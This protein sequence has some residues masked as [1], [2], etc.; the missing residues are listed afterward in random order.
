MKSGY[1]NFLEFSG[2][3][4]ACNGTALASFIVLRDSTVNISSEKKM[5]YLDLSLSLSLSLDYFC[6]VFALIIFV[7]TNLV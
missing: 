5:E 6:H 7:K 3:L 1:L 4:Q 2:P